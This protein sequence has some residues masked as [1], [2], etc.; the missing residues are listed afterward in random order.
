MLL[1]RIQQQFIDSADL[2]YQSAPVLAPLVEAAVAALLALVLTPSETFQFS[3]SLG[4]NDVSF[5]TN[6]VDKFAGDPLDLVPP[7]N[8]SVAADWTPR[9][10]ESFDLLVDNTAANPATSTVTVQIPANSPA[11]INAWTR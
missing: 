10:S 3:A 4:H 1:Q 7:Y 9:I 8:I 6:A 5:T 11:R 2:K